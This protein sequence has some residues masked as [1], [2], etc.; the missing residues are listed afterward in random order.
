[1][2][3]VDGILCV[4]TWLPFNLLYSI[5]AGTDTLQGQYSPR[6]VFTMDAVLVGVMI[7]NVFISPLV[8]YTFSVSFRVSTSRI[9]LSLFVY[10][11]V[12]VS[13]GCLQGSLLMVSA[14][15]LHFKRL[16]IS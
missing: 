7:C 4:L 10:L 9:R 11:A 6:Q 3:A 8:Y 1:M 14:L 5:V 16:H 2:L 12:G 13:R 15:L